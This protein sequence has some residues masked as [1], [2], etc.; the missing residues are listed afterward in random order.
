M[1]RSS[2]PDPDAHQPA[3]APLPPV[4]FGDVVEGVELVP[5]SVPLDAAA[6]SPPAVSEPVDPVDGVSLVAASD[7]FAVDAVFERLASRASFLAQPDP[8]NTMAGADRARFMGPPQR[9]H[10][11]GPGA[12]IPWITSTVCPHDSHT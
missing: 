11:A 6:F 2:R 5:L 7:A 4:A 12:D 10:A 1:P 8:L 3:A 9:S